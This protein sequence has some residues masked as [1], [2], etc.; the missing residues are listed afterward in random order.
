MWMLDSSMRM[1]LAAAAADAGGLLQT[2]SIWAIPAM[3]VLIPLW[4]SFRGVKVYESFIEGAEEGLQ[5][6]IKILPFLV[7]MMVA[8]AIFRESGAMEVLAGLLRPVTKP[9]GFPTEILPL[10]IVRPLSGAGAMA[11]VTDLLKLH[12]PDSFIG[13]LAS[14]LMGSTDTTFYVLTVYFGAV[15]IRRTR[16]AAAVGLIADAAGF[17][18]G[19][20]ACNWFFR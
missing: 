4:G 13:Q 1:G 17:V 19:L 15:G 8:L 16:Y 14:V 20:L 5:I 12:G 2:L 18:V 3:I 7:G 9:L 6:A 10:I 11:V